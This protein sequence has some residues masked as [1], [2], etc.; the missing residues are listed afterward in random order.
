MNIKVIGFEIIWS[1]HDDSWVSESFPLYPSLEDRKRNLTEPF[2]W[3]NSFNS[4]H[5]RPHY[6]FHLQ[7]DRSIQSINYPS[8][9][10][11]QK[12]PRISEYKCDNI[13]S[14]PIQ[15]TYHAGP[16][17]SGR[18]GKWF[19]C[20]GQLQQRKRKTINTPPNLHFLSLFNDPKWSKSN[21]RIFPTLKYSMP[22]CEPNLCFWRKKIWNLNSFITVKNNNFWL[23]M[24]YLLAWR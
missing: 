20:I 2:L 17:F 23:I 8:I 11:Q 24:P 10:E 15:K 5:V 1:L 3:R 4:P 18:N 21:E 12:L 16:L 19:N 7:T 22:A 6:C 14:G 9:D 13:F